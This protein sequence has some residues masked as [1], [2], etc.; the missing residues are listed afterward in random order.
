M[1]PVI[2][3]L[4]DLGALAPPLTAGGAAARFEA[5]GW[6]PG[7]RVRDGVETSWDADGAGAWIRT[8]GA[9]TVAVSFAVWIRDAD[10]SGCFD[11]LEAVYE[12]GERVLAGFLPEIERSSFAGRLDGA[13]RTPEG[14]KAAEGE[15]TRQGERPRQGERAAEGEGSGQGEGPGGGGGAAEDEAEGDG[16]FVAR[17]RW[18]LDGLVLTAGVV[19]H[20]T[21]LPVMVV[22][23][24]EADPAAPGPAGG[25]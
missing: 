15:G 24:L 18:T 19:H 12:E 20:D 16:E 10:E 9:G 13:G 1:T 21:D 4:E 5:R 22:V 7:G 11:D 8:S 17:E 3:M 23:T 25:G 6:T 2:A 14:E